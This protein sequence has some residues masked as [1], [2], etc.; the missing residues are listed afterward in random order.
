MSLQ[1]SPTSPIVP[2]LSDPASWSGRKAS[3]VVLA[4]AI[5]AFLPA[6]YRIARPFLT[7]FV[8]AGILAVALSPLRN[9]VGRFVSRSSMAALIT[10][11]VSMGPILALIFLAGGVIERGL[12]SG[13][14]SEILRAAERFTLNAPTN[15]EPI[16]SKVAQE[17]AA[18]INHI[19]GGIFTG[20]LA[21]VFVYV[22]LV[23]GQK[24]LAQLTALL[25]LD[26]TVT[27]RIVS[28]ARDAIVANVDGIVAVAAAQAVLF[29]MIFWI[30]GVGS[31]VPWGALA[32]LAS[33]VP[34]IGGTV[35]WLPMAV[36][37]AIHGT[38]MR[39]LLMGLGCLIGQTL[40]SEL[41]RPRVVGRRL[42]Q[43]A[44]LIALSVL[45]ATEAFGALGILLGPVIVAIL[46]A[47]VGELRN[48][49]ESNS[50]L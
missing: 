29:G 26:S 49:L 35:V 9:W 17:V 24:W 15:S 1:R 37:V 16:N 33:M 7:A 20:G 45:G 21:V 2:S 32:G 50:H 8:L 5:A 31:P 14:F 23:H 40:I 36:N 13:A 3:V 18:Q 34:V 44:L 28:T 6:M 38:W 25:P 10:T 46:A 41:L 27:N 22:L 19:A 11:L 48:Q 30:A 39:A 47:L 42:Q 43:P 12:K 4:L